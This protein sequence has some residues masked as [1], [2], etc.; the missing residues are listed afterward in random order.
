MAGRNAQL[1][2]PERRADSVQIH[3]TA[4]CNLHC[5]HCYS[6]GGTAYLTAEQFDYILREVLRYAEAHALAPG[7]A[8][9]CGGEPTLSPILFECIRKLRRAGFSGVSLLTNGSLLTNDFARQLVRAGCTAVQICIEGN[10]ET[11]NRIRNGSWDQVLR[12][13]EI[14]R[15]QGLR[16][17][18]QTTLHPLNYKQVDEIIAVCKGRVDGTAFL[19]QIPHNAKTGVL[20]PSQWLEVL[21][22]FF[23]GYC[24]GGPA[25][26]SFVSV[27]D[28]QWSCHFYDTGYNACAYLLS[29]PYLPT[30]EANGDVY[31]CRRGG[32]PIGNIFQ[33]RLER[34]FQ[35]SRVLLKARQLKDLNT[36]CRTCPQSD[37]CTGCRALAWHLKG[38]ILAEDP[39][40]IR[41]EISLARQRGIERSRNE[42]L[43]PRYNDKPIQPTATE[44]MNFMRVT[45]KYGPIV[46]DLRKRKIAEQRAKRRGAKVLAR[47]VQQAADDFRF[48]YRM[49]KASTF[50]RWL[51]ARD[52]SLNDFA[53]FLETDIL[54]QKRCG[55]TKSKTGRGRH[56]KGPGRREL[57]EAKGL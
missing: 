8:L 51:K 55:R 1:V 12:A 35:Q 20:T 42:I 21:E 10:R 14:C 29:E 44:V 11:H 5:L 36:R 37:H 46:D 19:K 39:L 53:Q 40:C 47:E 22:H 43:V 18:N 57:R 16:V 15:R 17:I 3:L 26:R 34:I 28:I 24:Q 32:I 9:L 4:A 23:K 7:W 6:S 27:R 25:Y 38:D 56:G 49:T 54:L 52:V 31:P 50:K 30:I 45:G 2:A 48:A 41:D 13:W 33:D